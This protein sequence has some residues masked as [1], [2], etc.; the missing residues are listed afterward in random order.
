MRGR[1]GRGLVAGSAVAVLAGL[2][3]PGAAGAWALALGAATLPVGLIALATHRPAA[4]GRPSPSAGALAAIWALLAGS[5]AGLLALAGA[6]QGATP[7]GLPLAAW[8]LL[9]G[10]GAAPLVLVAW[11]Y[12]AGFDPR[13]LTAADLER[14]RRKRPAE[15]PGPPDLPPAPAGDAP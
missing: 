12:V 13:G 1:V 11:V 5:A 6:P 7:G 9:L 2:L 14:L 4:S 10:L 8:L 15:R 3:W